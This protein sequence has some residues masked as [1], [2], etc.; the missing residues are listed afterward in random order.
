YYTGYHP[1]TLEKVFTA[2]TPEAKQGQRKYFFWYDRAYRDDIMR[3]LR[4]MHR[5]D[6]A[7]R[8]FGQTRF[9]PGRR[10]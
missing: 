3:S 7:T 1:Y 10:K 5:P 2:T 4:K 6:I 8:L 9:N